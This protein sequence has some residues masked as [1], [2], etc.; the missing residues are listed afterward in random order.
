MGAP[1]GRLAQPQ[2]AERRCWLASQPCLARWGLRVCAVES[3]RKADSHKALSAM[4]SRVRPTRTSRRNV[5][6]CPVGARR[7]GLAE[8]WSAPHLLRGACQFVHHP[9]QRGSFLIGQTHNR[10][11]FPGNPPWYSP[12]S[13]MGPMEGTLISKIDRALVPHPLLILGYSRFNFVRASSILNC[14]STPRC[15]ALVLSAPIP[16]SDW[17]QGSSP[18]RRSVR[19]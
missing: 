13:L 11:F 14:Q 18:M 5:R 12:V 3:A 6:L 19:H 1:R 10:L 15:L 7:I 4:F 16:I 8:P 17:S 2:R 9:I